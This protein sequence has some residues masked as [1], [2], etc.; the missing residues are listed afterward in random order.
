[1]G[2]SIIDLDT[3]AYAPL[4]LTS[5]HHGCCLSTTILS[6]IAVALAPILLVGCQEPC[7][8][9]AQQQAHALHVA[10]IH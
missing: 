9:V 10:A 1:M 3:Y 6:Q 8:L 4:S 7:Q 2:C 5:V